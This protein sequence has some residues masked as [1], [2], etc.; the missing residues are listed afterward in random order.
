MFSNVNTSNNLVTVQVQNEME[1]QCV[2]WGCGLHYESGTLDVQPYTNQNGLTPIT[3]QNMVDFIKT[4]TETNFK[5]VTQK[6]VSP[7]THI[8]THPKE[9]QS[10]V[11]VEEFNHNPKVH[12]QITFTREQYSNFM[13]YLQK[14]L[15]EDY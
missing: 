11:V 13:V 15:L 1:F 10:M 4:N 9:F 5:I 2:I 12:V 14:F 7:L 8:I 3:V 6:N